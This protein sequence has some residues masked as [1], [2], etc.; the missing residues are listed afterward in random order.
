EGIRAYWN[1]DHEELYVFR[2]DEHMDRFARSLKLV[3]LPETWSM[4]ELKSAIVDLLQSNGVREDTYIR[5]LAYRGGEG[6]GGFSGIGGETEILINTHPMPSHLMSGKTQHANVS[7]WR[8]ISENVMPPRI[9][10]ISNYRNSQ[11][12][13]MESNTSG[14]D[15]PV[16]LNDQGKVAEGPGA[17]IALIRD[18]KF[19]TPDTTQGIL[20][21]ITRDALIEL[22]R[23][24][25]G[26]V[27]EERA[28]DRTELYI[29]DEVFMVGTAAEISPIV[30]VDRYDVADGKIGPITQQ[31]EGLL[32]DCFRGRTGIRPEWRAP[33]GVA[34]PVAAD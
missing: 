1:P 9:K 27:I 15:V 24:E 8:R 23:T 21:S 34:K 25:L 14:Y 18:G 3:R 5:P 28:V 4:D 30:S 22:A 13:N 12:A 2:L 17:C 16:I 26:M 19:I 10:N 33:V 20:E 6:R 32:D 11:L 31:L 29:A 7:S